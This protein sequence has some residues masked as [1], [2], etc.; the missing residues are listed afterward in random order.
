MKCI[1]CKVVELTGRQTEFCSKSC[2]NKFHSTKLDGLNSGFDALHLSQSNKPLNSNN[3]NENFEALHLSQSNKPL[4]SNNKNENF[5]QLDG[6]NSGLNSGFDVSQSNKPLNSNNKNENFEQLDG[7]N[8]GLN[9]GFDALRLSQSNKPLNSNNKNENFEQLTNKKSSTYIERFWS[10]SLGSPEDKMTKEEIELQQGSVDFLNSTS[11]SPT[12]FQQEII[13]SQ[14]RS[15][16][17]PV[18]DS[19]NEENQRAIIQ[20]LANGDLTRE[21]KADLVSDL[22]NITICGTQG[23]MGDIDISVFGKVNAGMDT[24]KLRQMMDSLMFNLEVYWKKKT[25]SHPSLIEDVTITNPPLNGCHSY[26][27]KTNEWIPQ[28][29]LYLPRK[30]T[31]FILGERKLPGFNVVINLAYTK[32]Y[33]SDHSFNPNYD[34]ILVLH[35]GGDDHFKKVSEAAAGIIESRINSQRQTYIIS[36]FPLENGTLLFQIIKA[37]KIPVLSLPDDCKI[38][39]EPEEITLDE[40]SKRIEDAKSYLR[41]IENSYNTENKEGV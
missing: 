8:S 9:S 21:Q 3:K 18:W 29:K 24:V 7:L 16:S 14:K 12:K 10:K 39:M 22:T 30:E 19:L 41:L 35:V 28:T 13:V 6:L 23:L 34:G 26:D 25:R 33:E 37:Y 40:R 2:N 1:Q 20:A 31:C 32:E 27:H 5:E 11:I 36:K 38:F 15:S 17:L 4:N